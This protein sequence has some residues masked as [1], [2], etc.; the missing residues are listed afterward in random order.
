MPFTFAHP[1]AVMPVYRAFQRHTL[2][3]A[4]IIGS[5]VPDFQYFLPFD[6]D[7]SDSHSLAGVL[8][9]CLPVA[10]SLYLIFHLLLKRPLIGLCPAAVAVHLR[11]PDDK[12]P[13]L[14]REP[15]LKVV[16]S[17]LAGIAT[18]LAWDAL[19]HY[20][21]LTAFVV[22][23]LSAHLFSVGEYHVYPYKI[24]QHASTVAGTALLCLWAWRWLLT[25]PATVSVPPAM[26]PER[27]R[28]TIIGILLVT[29]PI[30]GLWLT[31]HSYNASDGLMRLQD[32]V[33]ETVTTSISMFGLLLL[34][35]SLAWLG[36]A[37]K[38]SA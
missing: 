16:A 28:Q 22:P 2:L 3:S 27:A 14:P 35:Y 32:F 8:W 23:V 29:P 37:D 26:L 13:L 33:R 34:A 18:H 36:L 30:L 9:F 31:I 7:R 10:M 21:Y 11:A 20:G 12:T 4:L 1:A 24:L 15:G 5:L 25:R 17:L 19:T 38:K 6:V